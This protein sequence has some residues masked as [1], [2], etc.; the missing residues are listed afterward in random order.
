MRISDWSSDVCYSDL[1]NSSPLLL[2]ARNT[3]IGR[4]INVPTTPETTTMWIVCS[5][6]FQSS[7][8]SIS[9]AIAEHL[10]G[11]SGFP[12]ETTGPLQRGRIG[13]IGDHQ[14]A[15]GFTADLVDRAG[16]N[17]DVRADGSEEHTSEFQSLM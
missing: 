3:P 5:R 10:R 7:A 6:P 14:R 8:M 13:G 1:G 4:P 2:V 12:V 15:I 16:E 11:K 17:V 9:G